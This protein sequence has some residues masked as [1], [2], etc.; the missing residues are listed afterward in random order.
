MT[1]ILSD[2]RYYFA[3]SYGQGNYSSCSYNDSTSCSTSG[4]SSSSGTLTN[5]GTMVLLVVSV[6]CLIIF[7]ALIVRFWRRPKRTKSLDSAKQPVLQ[8]EHK[9]K[10]K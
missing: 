8:S 3:Q 5:T 7:V 4:G 2:N 6:A 9:N 10:N 1:T